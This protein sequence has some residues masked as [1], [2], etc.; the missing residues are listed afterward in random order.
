MDFFWVCDQ[1]H[2]KFADVLLQK[3]PE[4]LEFTVENLKKSRQIESNVNLVFFLVV[5][6]STSINS[7]SCPIKCNAA[8]FARQL[9]PTQAAACRKHHIYV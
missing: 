2:D 9:W 8:T 5:I 4:V 3:S 6:G 1:V 7:C